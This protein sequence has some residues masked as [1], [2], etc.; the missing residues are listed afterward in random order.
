[1]AEHPQLNVRVDKTFLERIDDWRRS[2][3]DLPNR[4]EAV[5]RLVD[6]A[7]EKPRTGVRAHQKLTGTKRQGRTRKL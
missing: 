7:L 6:I 3:A 2:Q 5:R 1:M 4:P